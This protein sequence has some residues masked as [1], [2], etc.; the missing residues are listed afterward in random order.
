MTLHG[1]SPMKN[2]IKY[3]RTPHLPWSP[4]V[5]EDDIRVIDTK[6]FEGEEIVVTEK[7]DGE[8]TTLYP[9]HLHARSIDST[10]HPSRTQIK[11]IHG[12]IAH[13]IPKGW[14]ICGENLQACHSIHYS[15]LLDYFY[16]FSIWDENNMALSWEDTIFWCALLKLQ[17][18]PT[19]LGPCRWNENKVKTFTLNEEKQEG[20]VVRLARSFP[21]N[22]FN[23]STAK[24]VRANHVTTDDHWLQQKMIQN[25]KGEK[26]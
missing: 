18:V 23:K 20:Y 25:K 9:D 16:V 15:N 4:G 10:H 13:D 8:N 24:Y 19:L 26:R 22:Q 1:A 7:M 17:E 21:F 5:S 12:Q 14:R 3:P 2:Y 11:R 6:H